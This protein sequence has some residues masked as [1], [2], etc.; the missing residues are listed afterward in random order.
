MF[1]TFKNRWVPRICASIPFDLLQ[2]ICGLDV[3]IPYWHVVCDHE[4]PHVSGL[5]RFRNIRQFIAD[6]EFFLQRYS[7]VTEQDV[8]CHLHGGRALPRRSVLLTF[9]D[10]FR[11]VHDVIAPILRAK[12]APAV[13]FLISS[14]IDN[15]HLCYQHKKSL[16]IR[17]LTREQSSATLNEA[18]RLLSSAA[19]SIN[20][21]VPSGIKAVSYGQRHV[22]DDL[23]ELFHCD[24]QAYL[25]SQKPYLTSQ[26]VEGLMRQGFSVGAHSVDHPLY[27]ELSLEDQLLQTR[28][29]TRWLSERFHF[30]CQSFAFPY[31]DNGVSLEFFRNVF[32]DGSGLNV[33][34]GTLPLIPRAFPYNLPRVST[35]RTGL[36]AGE[37]LARQFGKSLLAQTR[38]HKI[39]SE[40]VKTPAVLM[41]LEDK[42]PRV[43]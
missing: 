40:T 31:G 9:D 27:A 21:N 26:Q 8:I 36:T 25:S 7:P 30:K 35:E 41:S 38:I 16:L 42:A 18:T 37:V 4:L 6:L 13:F 1:Q 23:G 15:R 34:F 33:S 17:A 22:L 14:A 2:M 39:Y 29:S 3:L 19:V 5:Y 12:G 11:E 20:S 28:E 43:P 24:F 32:A 10:G